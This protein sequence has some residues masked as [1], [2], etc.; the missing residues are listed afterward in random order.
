MTNTTRPQGRRTIIW[1]IIIGAIAANMSLAAVLTPEVA[2]QMTCAEVYTELKQRT[3]L[4]QQLGEAYLQTHNTLA[5]VYSSWGKRL[6]PKTSSAEAAAVGEHF[7]RAA[8]S[9]RAAIAQSQL[10]VEALKAETAIL[11]ERLGECLK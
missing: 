8:A 2:S 11:V 5:E 3:E 4:Y 1:A 6:T 9:N 10:T 7:L